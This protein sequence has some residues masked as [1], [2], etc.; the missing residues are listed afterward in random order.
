MPYIMDL[1]KFNR[2][3]WNCD[4]VNSV[5]GYKLDGH[6][7]MRIQINQSVIALHSTISKW[8]YSL[9]GSIASVTSHEHLTT[10]NGLIELWPKRGKTL[11]LGLRA[12]RHAPGIQANYSCIQD[13][14]LQRS[15]SQPW[16]Q[17]ILF[18]SL[19]KSIHNVPFISVHSSVGNAKNDGRPGVINSWT[20]KLK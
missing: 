12:F 14:L 18:A 15:S 20:Q 19:D 9:Y 11:V 5:P 4:F 2:V 6:W 3:S 17:L 16:E 7:L 8:R 1:E 13:P 10:Q